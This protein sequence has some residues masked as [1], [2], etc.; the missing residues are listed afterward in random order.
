M[1]QGLYNHLCGRAARR[2]AEYKGE[3]RSYCRAS[4]VSDWEPTLSCRP[5]MFINSRDV[6]FYQK[7]SDARY[8]KKYPNT[9]L[10]M[11]N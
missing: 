9:E 5:L 8:S 2:V 3:V 1:S 10:R 4:A 11:S 6:F 7:R